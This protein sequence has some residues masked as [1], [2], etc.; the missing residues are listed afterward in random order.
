MG[1]NMS[2]K[3]TFDGSF[4]RFSEDGEYETAL[5]TNLI[6]R[7]YLEEDTLKDKYP[8]KTDEEVVEIELAEHEQRLADNAAQ[9]AAIAA[10]R[11]AQQ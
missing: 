11:E 3:I 2:K 8:G 10:E 4:P 7:F 9:D 1:N 6:H 5:D